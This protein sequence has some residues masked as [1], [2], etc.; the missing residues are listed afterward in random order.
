MGKPSKS[1]EVHH[2]VHVYFPPT[3]MT[4]FMGEPFLSFI[5]HSFP[6][7]DQHFMASTVDMICSW[8]CSRIWPFLFHKPICSNICNPWC[9]NMHTNICPKS[10]NHPVAGSFLYT[11]TMGCRQ[12]GSVP[13]TCQPETRPTQWPPWIAIVLDGAMP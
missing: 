12:M 10:Q 7:K 9:W 11:S 6:R 2:D 8:I 13:P 1:I 3:N 4:M 5:L